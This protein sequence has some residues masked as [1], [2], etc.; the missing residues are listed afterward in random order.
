MIKSYEV[1]SICQLKFAIRAYLAKK[2][3]IYNDFGQ[4][5]D[6]TDLKFQL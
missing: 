1:L 4:T 2:W 3:P 5:S 6:F